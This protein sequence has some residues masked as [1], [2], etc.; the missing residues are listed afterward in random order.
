MDPAGR[1]AGGVAMAGGPPKQEG[2]APR[3]QPG[4]RG[5][6]T[7]LAA[8][9][10]HEATKRQRRQAMAVNAYKPSHT[11]RHRAS[12]APRQETYDRIAN[13]V[14]TIKAMTAD[15]KALMAEVLAEMRNTPQAARR[16]CLAARVD[17]GAY[18]PSDTPE[19][20][21]TQR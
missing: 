14:V 4:R 6:G 5:G 9:L 17:F 20:K 2:C 16:R 12:G 19:G 10:A 7:A 3:L 15:I 13:G 18:R 8:H 11:N 21:G 1:G